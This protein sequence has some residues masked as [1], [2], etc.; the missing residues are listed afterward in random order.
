L[1]R[2][3]L[4][5]DGRNTLVSRRCNECPPLTLLKIT[6]LWMAMMVCLDLL[7]LDESFAPALLT[8]RARNLR[9]ETGNFSLHAK[10]EE[11]NVSLKELGH[12]YLVRPFQM[13]A[14]PILFCIAL[15]SSFVYGILYANL[16]AFPVVYQQGRKWDKVVGALPFLSIFVGVLF[17]AAA[18]VANQGYF[19]R[20]LE[21]N[22]N[23]P[24]PEARLPPMMAGSVFFAA[25]LFIFAW[26]SPAHIHWAYSQIGAACVGFGFFTIIQPGINY[27]VDT[28][29][30]SSAS[31]IAAMTLMRS[32]TAGGLP[33]VIVQLLHNLGVPWGVSLF[34]FIAIAL[35]P[36]PF[37]FF[38]YGKNLRLRGTWSKASV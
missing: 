29:A 3:T 31:A 11:W 22:N 35:I 17:G 32:M 25:G 27:V 19:T 16:G 13:L 26:T 15:Y 8:K 38:V 4:V 24:L 12:K 20:K 23:K 9:Y 36:I 28:F 1:C 7:F 6:G 10:H 2:V 18:N 30:D 14:T 5:G 34:G 37:L 33:L 21:Q